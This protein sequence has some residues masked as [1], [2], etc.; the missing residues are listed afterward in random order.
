M[1]GQKKAPLDEPGG[2]MYK[3]ERLN[4]YKINQH[5]TVIN[6]HGYYMILS[7][8][9]I[10]NIIIFHEPELLGHKRG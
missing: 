5:Q 7:G 8:S 4:C 10:I 3:I 6:I 2:L 1:T 9:I